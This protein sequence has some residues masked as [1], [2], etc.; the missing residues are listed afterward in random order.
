MGGSADEK[1][2]TSQCKMWN[3]QN[4]YPNYNTIYTYTLSEWFKQPK[5][6]NELNYLKYANTPYFWGDDANYKQNMVNYIT[7][8]DLLAN[9]DLENEL[10]PL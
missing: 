6:E 10:E 2:Q 8:Y 1:L 4:M 9:Y 3:Y 5:Y 7:N